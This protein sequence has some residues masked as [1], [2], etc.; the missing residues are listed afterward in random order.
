MHWV[1]L[2]VVGRRGEEN[3]MDSGEEERRTIRV[4]VRRGEERRGRTL[5]RELALLILIYIAAIFLS[6]P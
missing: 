5:M 1:P 2:R 3:L 6:C 4:V